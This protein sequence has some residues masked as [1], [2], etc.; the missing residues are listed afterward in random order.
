MVRTK[1]LAAKGKGKATTSVPEQAEEV[2]REME[3]EEEMIA[4]PERGRAKRR[5]AA[6][7]RAA[8]QKKWEESLRGRGFKNERHVDVDN[9]GI[10]NPFVRRI[11]EQGLAYY[12][13]PNPGYNKE[14]V[15]EFYKNMK[16]PAKEDEDKDDAKITSKIGKVSIEVTSGFIARLLNYRQPAA[17]N[18]NYPSEEYVADD[19]IVRELYKNPGE[20]SLPHVPGRFK[21]KVPKSKFEER[22]KLNPGDI[23]NS[24]LTRSISQSRPA[25]VAAPRGAYLTT[26]P[27]KGARAASWNKLLFCQG[28][29]IMGCMKKIKKETRDNARRQRRIDHKLDWV[30]SRGPGQASEPYEPPPI[31][32]DEDSD[33]FAG[34]EPEFLDDE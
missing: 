30:V 23:N 2:V 27:P 11:Q 24:I 4:N 17:N 15:I 31:E 14:L 3:E 25:A 16:I 34:G 22:E 29:A 32:P 21:D 12:L 10:E 33:D 5:T 13:A 20:A 26:L 19:T 28:V 1:T 8:N 6:E 7:V 9:L 18:V